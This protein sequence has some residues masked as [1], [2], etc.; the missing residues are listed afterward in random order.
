MIPEDFKNCPC[1]ARG[2]I[3]HTAQVDLIREQMKGVA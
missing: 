2:Q 3:M 1:H